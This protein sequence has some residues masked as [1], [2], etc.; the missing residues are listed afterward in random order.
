MS[1]NQNER[2]FFNSRGVSVTN[3]RFITPGET[4]AMRNLTSVKKLRENP[5]MAL[6]A[7][8]SIIGVILLFVGSI[9]WGVVLLGVGVVIGL[10]SKL[11]FYVQLSSSSGESKALKDQDETFI[12]SVIGALNDSIVHRG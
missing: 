11:Y 12:D 6:P 3:A 7:I 1:E 10:I 8:F 9:A 4:Y 2:E 5:S